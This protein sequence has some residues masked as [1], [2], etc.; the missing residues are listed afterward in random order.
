MR[1]FVLAL[2]VLAT[3]SAALAQQQTLYRLERIIVEGSRVDDT[4]VRGEARLDEEKMYGE[5]DF[6]QAVYRVRRLPFVTDATYRIEP[7]VTAG[8]TT[9]VIRI[10]DVTPVFYDFNA[11]G[12]RLADGETVRDGSALLGGRWLLNN[13]GVLEG[14]VQKSDNLDGLNVGLAYR[15]YNIMGTGGFASLALAQRFK[16]KIRDYD[17]SMVATLGYPLT[18][19][20]TVTL[21]LSKSGSSVTREIDLNN[22]DDDD[23]DDD[24][25]KDDNFDLT[26]GDS[27]TFADLR[28][29][30]ES[31][32]DPIFATRGVSV[33]GGP[34][35]SSAKFTFE[36]Y[37]AV[38]RKI[39]P[40]ELE[41]EAY[42]VGL[43]ASAYHVLFGRNVGFIRLS[44]NGTRSQ[45]V[46]VE[47]LDGVARAGIAHDFHS[48]AANV[49]RP[50]KAR[51]EVGAAYRTTRRTEPGL[52]EVS[53][54]DTAAEA[55][56]VLRHRWGTFRLTGTYLT[57]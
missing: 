3:A 46:E 26:N 48:Y 16:S 42:G 8:G 10:L 28:W 32:D 35:W 23:D 20:Q 51:I 29:W 4:I 33:S 47:T 43:D 19:R 53:D 1:P 57:D 6:R 27:L 15:A 39:V 2:C 25:D 9:L 22:D 41:T 37:D 11:S 50:I 36:N 56:F 34:N 54:N 49:L 31:I 52:D 17:P 13:L 24:S 14:A 45:E 18:Q 40:G 55:A 21:A 44:G 7:G 5:E 38:A 30:Y 12:T